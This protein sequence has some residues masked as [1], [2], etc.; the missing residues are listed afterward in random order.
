MS[1]IVLYFLHSTSVLSFYIDVVM[2]LSIGVARKTANRILLRQSA[3]AR[4]GPGKSTGAPRKTTA[5]QEWALFRMIH[6]DCFLQ[7]ARALTERIRN[8]YGVRVGRKMIN[9]RLAA[10]GYPLAG[11][12]G[13]LCWLPIIAGSASTGHGGGRNGLWL[14]GPTSSGDE[15]RFQLYP[16]DGR[17]R[18]R[19]LSGER[20]QPDCQAA[21]FQAGWGSFHVWGGG[22][23]RGHSTRVSNHP[24]CSWIG[25]PMTWCIGTFARLTTLSGICGTNWGVQSTTWITPHITLM[26]SARPVGSVGQYPCG[27]PSFC[28]LFKWYKSI[29]CHSCCCILS[30]WDTIRDGSQ[31]I[32]LP[33]SCLSADTYGA[34]LH[35]NT[36][37]TIHMDNA[38][39]LPTLFCQTTL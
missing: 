21:R 7:S 18:V 27:T 19:R 10:R 22:G 23:G 5:R 14:I 2:T 31:W 38:C 20:F 15:S 39:Y 16:V 25:M 9:N 11:S 36:N 3:S 37:R 32:S 24:L 8:V 26:N 12:W 17:M 29:H 33:P 13:S 28:H 35:S 1:V 4:L 6:E 30:L 34:D